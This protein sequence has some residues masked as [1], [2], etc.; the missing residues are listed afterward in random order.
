MHLNIESYST[1]S[2][3]GKTHP[4][5]DGWVRPSLNKIVQLFTVLTLLLFS[6]GKTAS[7]TVT[8]T[9]SNRS[10]V[11]Q[12]DYLVEI[13][14]DKCPLPIGNYIVINESGE[15]APLE[16]TSDLHGNPKA[17]FP[18]AELSG[19]ASAVFRMQKGIA[20]EYPKRTYAELS[21]KIGGEFTGMKYEGGFSWVKPNRITVD[22]TFRDHAYYIKYEGPGWE[23][24]KVGFRFYLD[25]RNGI[26]VFGKKTPDIVLPFVGVDGYDSYHH[27]A[28]WGMDN[29]KVGA[30]LGLGSIAV[31]DGEK[32]VRV[33]KREN[34]TC[35]IPTDGKLRSQVHTTYYGWNANGVICNLQS[36][37][38]IDAGSRASKMELQVDKKIDNFATGIIKDKNTEVFVSSNPENEWSYIATFG[39]QSLNDDMMG[40]AIFFRTKQLQKITQDDLNHVVVLTPDD[41]YVEYY[42]M[43]A[44]ELDWEPVKD[45]TTFEA[46]INEVLNR[47]NYPLSVNIE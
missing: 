21:H 36:L 45:R 16:I 33:E 29:M 18:V 44:W 23:S 35:F 12:K 41:G 2:T 1:I 13:P 30:T 38:T 31:W 3:L 32:A 15:E 24:D 39:K 43:P 26:D 37:I 34:V 28:D 8:V 42:F 4:S 40:L 17:V 47:L 11:T 20:A 6:S 19:N 46:C 5:A 27:M 14:I 7:Q 10:I 9:V 25:Q 22:S